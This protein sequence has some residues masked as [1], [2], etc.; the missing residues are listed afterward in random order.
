[1]KNIKKITLFTYH[2]YDTKIYFSYLSLAQKDYAD[3]RVW[4]A[5]I[6]WFSFWDD[7]HSSPT[8]TDHNMR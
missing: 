1:M 8:A 3:K 6:F 2:I 4:S 5:Y 7:Y